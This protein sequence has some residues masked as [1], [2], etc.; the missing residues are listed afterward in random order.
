[1]AAGTHLANVISSS[2]N[3]SRSNPLVVWHLLSLDAPS[4]AALWTWFIARANRIHLPFNSVIAMAIAVW[5]LYAA[6]RLLDSRVV[7]SVPFSMSNELEERH[8]FHRSNYSLFRISIVLASIALAMLL[9]GL[10]SA[11]TRLYLFLGGLLFGYFVLIHASGTTTATTNRSN[12]LPKELAV[13]IFFSAATFIPTV[14]R[15]PA[16]RLALIPGA[17]LFAVL[18]S[19][20]CLFIY[21]WEHRE[22]SSRAHPA[23][24]LAL[25]FLPAL[26]TSAALLGLALAF[27]DSYLP[28]PIPTACASAVLLLLTLHRSRSHLSPTPLR[29]AADLCLLTPLLL[30]PFLPR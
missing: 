10:A 12:R 13:G 1:M 6:D 18:C 8:Y 27:G 28:W 14:S 16:L 19:L 24:R 3:A 4:V 22:T 21:A 5:M 7:S 2:R 30:L 17:L 29:A 20:N 25:R 26:A 15:Q 9:P 11:A 23:T